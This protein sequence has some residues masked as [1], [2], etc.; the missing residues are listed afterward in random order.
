[1]IHKHYTFSALVRNPLLEQAIATTDMLHSDIN[2]QHTEML[3]NFLKVLATDILD[4]KIVAGPVGAFVYDD[5]NVGPTA[6]VCISTSHLA[7]HIWSEEKPARVELDVYSC[8][9]FNVADVLRHLDDN[10]DVL[11]VRVT[12]IDRNNV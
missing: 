3:K 4:M 12:K 5:G 2:E 9:D 7:C 11:K 10:M 1:M 6:A 8:K